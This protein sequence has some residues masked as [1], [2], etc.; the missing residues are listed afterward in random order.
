MALCSAAGPQ[1]SPVKLLP[2]SKAFDGWTREGAPK[3]FSGQQLFGHINGG[4]EI[5]LQYGFEELGIARYSRSGAGA[6]QEITC[7]IYRLSSAESAFGIFSIQRAGGERIS[8]KIPSR[9]WISEMQV[10][11]VKD[12]FYVNVL[13]FETALTALEAFSAHVVQGIP[14]ENISLPVLDRFPE[15]NRAQGSFRLI[16]GTLAAAEES[17]LLKEDFWGFSAGT[18]AYS[19]RYNPSNSKA[20]LIFSNGVLF[21]M[22]E[23]EALFSRY[24]DDVE[25]EG[26]TLSGVNA[27]GSWFL[28]RSEE[29]RTALVL[30]ERDREFASFLLERILNPR[31]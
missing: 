28:C 7:E 12:R 25:L 9:N 21:S 30:G 5:F 14:G 22:E 3:K 15:D 20:V 18:T 31:R 6:K 17:L 8:T 13:G 16:Q 1:Q 4:A 19:A 23:V 26:G 29:G 11:A 10:S 27:A 2:A 24:L